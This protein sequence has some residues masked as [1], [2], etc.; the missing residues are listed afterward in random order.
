[1]KGDQRTT[2][3]QAHQAQITGDFCLKDRLLYSQTHEI[4]L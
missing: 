3:V 1:M 2:K 4:H